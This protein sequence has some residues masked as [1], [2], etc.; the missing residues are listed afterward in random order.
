MFYTGTCNPAPRAGVLTARNPAPDSQMWGSIRYKCGDGVL[1]PTF[2]LFHSCSMRSL[3]QN[4]IANKRW[5][6]KTVKLHAGQMPE[7][8]H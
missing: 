1:A 8:P 3:A 2:F 5:K 7:K 6:V 4:K